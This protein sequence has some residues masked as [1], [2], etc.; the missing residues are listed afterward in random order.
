MQASWD[1]QQL[2]QGERPSHFTLRRW[3]ASQARLTKVEV[4]LVDIGAGVFDKNGE[5]DGDDKE[6]EQV[7]SVEENIGAIVVVVVGGSR[8][9]AAGRQW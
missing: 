7:V 1:E 8:E 2:W 6:V 9:E 3:Q 4:D 5:D